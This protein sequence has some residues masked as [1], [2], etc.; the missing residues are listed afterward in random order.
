MIEK[1]LLFH[2]DGTVE[3]Y[4]MRNSAPPLAPV[5]EPKRSR[6]RKPPRK[7][8]PICDTLHD[9]VD[10]ADHLKTHDP[11]PPEVVTLAPDGTVGRSWT[12]LE[13]EAAEALEEPA[14]EEPF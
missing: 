2:D 1:V 9:G 8:C 14:E 3:E 10:F 11:A 4:R 5:A 13:A 12:E 7:R 6:R